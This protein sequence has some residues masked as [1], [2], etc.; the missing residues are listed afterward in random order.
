MGA[1]VSKRIRIG[2]KP[3][4][5]PPQLPI[6]DTDQPPSA[7]NVVGSAAS[8]KGAS[9]DEEEAVRR[10]ILESA[11]FS[12]QTRTQV[13]DFLDDASDMMDLQE[14]SDVPPT[15]VDTNI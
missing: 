14:F 7:R 15:L 12:N 2:S 4:A 6:L 11:D 13:P 1:G 3:Q 10:A 5:R 8:S 9:Y